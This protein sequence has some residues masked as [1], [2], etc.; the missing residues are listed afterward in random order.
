MP[1]LLL[2]RTMRAAPGLAACGAIALVSL[3]IGR[4]APAVGSAA[5]AIAL[6]V[7]CAVLRA[8]GPALHPGMAWASGPGLRVAIVLLGAGLPIQSVVAAGA[9][10]LPVMAATLAACALATVVVGRV[11]GVGR[12]LRT[13]VGAGTGICGASAIAAIAPVIGAS[14]AEIA[15]AMST[16]FLFNLLA[17]VVF[18]VLG[19]ALGLDAHAFGVLAGTAVNDTSSVIAAAGVFGGGALA[20]AVAV[21]LVR[22][23]AIIPLSIALSIG[24][25][26]RGGGGSPLTPSRAATL[27]PWFLIGFALLALARSAGWIPAGMQDAVSQASGFLIAAALAGVGLSTDIRA[28]LRAGWRPLGLGA[29]LSAVV[30]GTA[31]AVMS[32]FGALA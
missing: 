8:P 26:R 2:H 16:I 10:A 23:L 15:Y 1:Q 19:H 30:A 25:S 12:R 27:V 28:V 11:L 20:V 31:L 29:I 22:T 18:P 32:A 4:A 14:S 17:V 21:K 6:G 3:V 5:P 7:G 9:E 13:L 24:E